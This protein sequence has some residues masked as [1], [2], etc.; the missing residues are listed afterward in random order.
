[1]WPRDGALVADAMSLAGYQSVI[2]PFFHFCSQALTPEGYLNH[3]FN[4]DG[5]VGS[6]WHPFIVQGAKAADPRG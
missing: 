6:S 1:M 4:P 3:K 2:A 5:T